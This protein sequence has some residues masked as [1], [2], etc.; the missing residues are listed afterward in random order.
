MHE[1]VDYIHGRG[2]RGGRH[3]LPSGMLGTI[4]NSLAGDVLEE[5]LEHRARLLVNEARDTLHTAT[6]LVMPWMLTLRGRAT[7]SIVF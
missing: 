1:G 5:H 6:G 2:R 7:G 4:G 3:G